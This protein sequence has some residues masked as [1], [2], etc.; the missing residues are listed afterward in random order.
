MGLET[1]PQYSEHLDS[2]DVE[3][4]E[5]VASDQRETRARR[6]V[7]KSETNS[8]HNDDPA[9]SEISLRSV[10]TLFIPA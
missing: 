6:Q 10:P 8:R 1:D 9:R 3:D 7:T 2:T 5:K 4:A